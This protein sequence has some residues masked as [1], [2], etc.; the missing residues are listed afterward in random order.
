MNTK[1]YITGIRVLCV[2]ALLG[3]VP[4]LSAQEDVSK[5]KKDRN[6]NREM[7]LEKEYDPSVQDASKVNSLPVIKEPVIRK[8]PIDYSNF[9]IP[10]EPD[11]ELNILGSGNVMTNMA[12]NKRRGYFHF[13][14]GNYTNLNGDLGY[15]I[16]STEKDKLGINFSHRSTN[17]KITYLQIDEKQKAK[18]NDNLG[19]INYEHEFKKLALKLGAEYGYT[20]F[21]YYGYPGLS[22]SSASSIIPYTNQAN[23]QIFFKAGIESKVETGFNYLLDID[24]RNFS[25]KY[26][27]NPEIDGVKENT[28]G[29]KLDLN[30]AFGGNKKIGL[31][32]LTEYLSYSIPSAEKELFEDFF[33]HAEVTLNPYFKVT[34]ENWKLNLGVNAMLITGKESSFTA[35]PNIMADVQVAEATV[36]YANLL[37]DIRANSLYQ[38]AQEN[39][40]ANP[41]RALKA[42]RTWLDG[43][44]GIKTGAAP[45]FWVDVFAGY[46]ITDDDHFYIPQLNSTNEN[47]WGN[48]SNVDYMNAKLFKIGA[49]LKY[50]YQ[51]LIDMSLKG[52]YNSWNVSGEY[53]IPGTAAT[54]VSAKAYNRPEMELDATIDVKPVDKLTV[55]LNYYLGAGRYTFLNGANEKMKNINDL[56]LKGAYAFNDTF[57]CYVKLNNL[58]FQKYD[59]F[60]G[61]TAQGFNAMVGINLNF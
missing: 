48:V 33:N 30:S 55:S 58:M 10:V 57:G 47:A 46:K 15:H 50:S 4:Q 54:T 35:S 21:N 45:G 61:Y 14:G 40:Y 26:A 51:Q 11:K 16:L 5:D 29:A 34:G 13:G 49:I 38:I 42:S 32:V 37:G 27:I 9:T 36:L 24:Y 28:I 19:A 59:M 25:H 2:A 7:T 23:Q 8:M 43:T 56:N 20:A 31:K 3:A 41:V 17:G 53:T 18:L 60:Y 1:L 6:V 12:F 22:T 44:I 39:R 52:V